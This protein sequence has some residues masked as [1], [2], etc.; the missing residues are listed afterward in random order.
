MTFMKH[1]DYLHNLK[2][3]IYVFNKY[4]ECIHVPSTILGTQDATVKRT[5]Q[6][7]QNGASFVSGGGH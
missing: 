1:D 4:V 5:E 3:C 7:L 2:F 6:T